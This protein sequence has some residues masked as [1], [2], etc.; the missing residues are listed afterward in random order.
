MTT[1]AHLSPAQ[2]VSRR[3]PAVGQSASARYLAGLLVL[4]AAYYGTAKIGQTLRYTGSVSAI[5]P[6]AGLGIAALYLGG[7]RWWPGVFLGELAVN[8]ELLGTLPLGSLIGQ[9]AG[10]M[11]EIVVGALLLH[12]LIGRRAALDRA[13]QVGGMLAA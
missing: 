11:A 6:P 13:D 7:L 1:E 4:A 9:Q 12:R 10:N 8:G 3:A 5:W 2:P